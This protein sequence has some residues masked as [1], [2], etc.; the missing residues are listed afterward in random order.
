MRENA[1]N[2]KIVLL[3]ITF[4]SSSLWARTVSIQ[5]PRHPQ[6]GYEYHID[7][8][9]DGICRSLGYSHWQWG[10]NMPFYSGR[11]KIKVVVDSYGDSVKV[12]DD[13]KQEVKSLRCYE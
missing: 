13:F 9:L 1:N 2:M 5:N 8:S 6:T 10:S 7:S 4:F 11:K 12:I 3:F